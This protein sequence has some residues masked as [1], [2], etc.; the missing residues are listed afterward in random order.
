MPYII[1]ELSSD[2]CFDVVYKGKTYQL[3]KVANLSLDTI[4]S[5]G[6]FSA[7]P[8]DLSIDTAVTLIKT[9]I[10]DF[11]VGELAVQ[12]QVFG[13]LEAWFADSGI[14]LGELVASVAKSP[15]TD[16]PSKL[17]SSTGASA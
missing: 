11:P 15:G 10:P 5:I 14:S 4:E 13:L 6:A 8:G 12:K 9:L 1:P 3:P 17:T 7:S 2:D 16:Q